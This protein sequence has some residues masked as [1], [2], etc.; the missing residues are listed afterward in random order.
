MPKAAAAH[1]LTVD[2]LARETGLTVRN[3]RAYQ[4][5]GLLPPPEVRAR[6]GYYG[7]EHLERLR[8]I[9]QLQ[10]EGFN[11][12]A[13]GRLL[14]LSSDGQSEAVQ[15]RSALLNAF[16]P[17]APEVI[18]AD[19]LAKRFGGPLDPSMM[20]K[21]E[22]VGAL[23]VQ[24]DGSIELTNPTLMRAAQELTEIG[25]PLHH[26]LAVGES[27]AENVAAISRQFVRLFVQDVLGPLEE[28]GASIKGE[29]WVNARDALERLR[30]LAG[31]AVIAAFQQA[32]AVA[33]E[34]EVER[35]VS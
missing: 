3:V 4:S 2:E 26:A 12:K 30:P 29:H 18:D 34:H 8:R 21:A 6:T 35:R 28:D 23:R 15:F 32:M 14:D 5:R 25:I 17:A 9:R 10:D 20:R 24:P 7:P 1:E 13:V 33:V 11:L 19:E 16:E 22:K 27:I 31:E